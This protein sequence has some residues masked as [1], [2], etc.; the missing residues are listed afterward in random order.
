MKYLLI[1]A[2]VLGLVG[3]EP[4]PKKA[5]VSAAKTIIANRAKFSKEILVATNECVKNAN[6]LKV[7]SDSDNDSAETIEACKTQA[8]QAYGAYSPWFESALLEWANS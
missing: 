3:C 5:N 8:Q 1:T 2:L 7:L 6:S 4:P